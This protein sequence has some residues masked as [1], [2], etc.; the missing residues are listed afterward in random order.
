LRPLRE[1]DTIDPV[2]SGPYQVHGRVLTGQGQND[3]FTF[4]PFEQTC[5]LAALAPSKTIPESGG[6]GAMM[7]ASARSGASN[8]A[9]TLS[10]P[11][12]PL[13]N[14]TLT[15]VSGFH[16][17]PGVPNPLAGR[18]YVLL[19]DSYGDTLAKAGLSV[20]PGTSPYKYVGALCGTRSPDC[21]RATDAIKSDAASA[22]RAD[23]NGGGTF[24]PVSPG[25]YYLMISTIYNRQPLVWGQAVQVDAGPNSITIDLRN[26]TSLN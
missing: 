10:T 7:T 19:R 15:I 12:A 16:M 9:S 6:T 21:Q 13:G 4:A 2:A 14:A 25:T 17:Q 22:V 20:P 8:V 1:R 24:P 5:E 23:A 26:A 3:D 18:P 11:G